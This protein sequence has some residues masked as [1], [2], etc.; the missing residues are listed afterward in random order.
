MMKD[1]PTIRNYGKV[2]DDY[3]ILYHKTEKIL[4]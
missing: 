2:K 1:E 4:Q 3:E